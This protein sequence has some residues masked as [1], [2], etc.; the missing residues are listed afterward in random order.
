MAGLKKNN[1]IV[2]RGVE[3]K[4]VD[5]EEQGRTDNHITMTQ[6]IGVTVYLEREFKYKEEDTSGDNAQR[7]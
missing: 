5:L 1:T 6:N 4:I 2:Y 7:A 3:F